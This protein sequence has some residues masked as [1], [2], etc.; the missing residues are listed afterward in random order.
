[1]PKPENIATIWNANLFVS[2]P[3]NSSHLSACDGCL[4]LS[5]SW[6]LNSV[7]YQSSTISLDD[8]ISPKVIN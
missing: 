7:D 5:V 4:L 1:M 3:L 6:R 8:A 2:E